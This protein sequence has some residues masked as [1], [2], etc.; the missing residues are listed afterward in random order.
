MPKDNILL[1]TAAAAE[2]LGVSERTLIFWRGRG[3]GPRFIRLGEHTI[4]YA[5]DDLD[6]FVET[7]RMDPA[8]PVQADAIRNR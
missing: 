4:R 3:Q 7:A 6:A 5:I 2:R 8:A 1:D